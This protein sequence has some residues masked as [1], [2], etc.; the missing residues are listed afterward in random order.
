MDFLDPDKD[1]MQFAE[2]LKYACV[3]MHADFVKDFLL[4]FP[5]PKDMVSDEA[6]LMLVII[7]MHHRLTMY[8][9]EA[10]HAA[11]RKALI[12]RGATWATEWSDL[13]SDWVLLRQRVCEQQCQ[14]FRD[15]QAAVVK[16]DA[17]G[18][19]SA[20]AKGNAIGPYRA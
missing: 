18:T 3:H 4:L 12:V 7:A 17:Q 19:E 14:R 1:H 2:Q 20:V 10:R 8:R 5:E 15:A 11:I 13:C 6:K 9:I 16:P